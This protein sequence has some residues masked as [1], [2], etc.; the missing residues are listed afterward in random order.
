MRPIKAIAA[1]ERS[2]KSVILVMGTLKIVLKQ[3]HIEFDFYSLSFEL[4]RHC[5]LA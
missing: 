2:S 3:A 1:I 5:S 4:H